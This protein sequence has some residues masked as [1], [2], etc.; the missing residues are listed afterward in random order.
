V[1]SSNE[2][3]GEGVLTGMSWE[4]ILTPLGSVVTSVCSGGGGGEEEERAGGM[5]RPGSGSSREGKRSA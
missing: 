1:K 4:A 5:G 3:G 2:G